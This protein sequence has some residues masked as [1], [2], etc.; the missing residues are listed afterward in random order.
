LK[1]ET[2]VI[3]KGDLVRCSRQECAHEWE[4]RVDN[5]KSCTKCHQYDV[6]VLVRRAAAKKK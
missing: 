1:S 3:H 6:V 5:P 2:K 4:A